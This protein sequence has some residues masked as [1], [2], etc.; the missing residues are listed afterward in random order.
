MKKIIKI[1]INFFHKKISLNKLLPNT[2]RAF[3]SIYKKNKTPS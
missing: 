2:L 1:L 3:V